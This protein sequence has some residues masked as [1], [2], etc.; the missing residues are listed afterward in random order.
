MARAAARRRIAETVTRL[1]GRDGDAR[2][3]RLNLA[4]LMDASDVQLALAA[5]SG[6]AE[7][8]RIAGQIRGNP[9]DFQR[10]ES[11]HKRLMA[12]VAGVPRAGLQARAL[13]SAAFSLIHR[14]ALFEYLRDHRLR[15]AD[16]RRLIG[17]FHGQ[18][19]HTRAVVTEHANYLCSAA[20]LVC[21]RRIGAGLLA[22]PAFGD[23]LPHYEQAYVEYFAAYCRSVL[24]TGDDAEAEHTHALLILLKQEVLALRHQLIELP[25]PRPARRA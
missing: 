19:S 15:G 1:L 2:L 10:W 8:R 25:V 20:S 13:L 18:G 16:R 9:R 6:S 3:P 12:T 11:G 23:P 22:H 17:H 7:Q 21:V 5:R 4:Q 24:A 14:K